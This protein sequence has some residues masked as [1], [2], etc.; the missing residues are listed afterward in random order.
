MDLIPVLLPVKSCSTLQPGKERAYLRPLTEEEL[1]PVVSW[2]PVQDSPP[3]ARRITWS[4]GR[5]RSGIH[6]GSHVGMPVECALLAGDCTRAYMRIWRGLGSEPNQAGLYETQ[7][8][9]SN[10]QCLIT[11]PNL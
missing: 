4:W 6:F 9:N 10:S 11:Q 8:E 1:E 2:L 7:T 5:R 3:L